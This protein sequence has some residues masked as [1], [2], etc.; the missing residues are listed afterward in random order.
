MDIIIKNGKIN[1]DEMQKEHNKKNEEGLLKKDYN[2]F[3]RSIPG[4]YYDLSECHLHVWKN[5]KNIS[6]FHGPQDCKIIKLFER[7]WKE[8]EVFCSIC[9]KKFKQNTA[10]D[11][12]NNFQNIKKENKIKK[13]KIPINYTC[14]WIYFY[15]RFTDR[16]NTIELIKTKRNKIY[17]KYYQLIY[18]LLYKPII[19]HISF[20]ESKL[21][22]PWDLTPYQKF[23]L[24]NINYK[25]NCIFFNTQKITSEYVK[26]QQKLQIL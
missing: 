6:N 16:K 15:N 12:N 4:P 21:I 9:H 18:K 8:N 2:D 7:P 20:Y 1:F 25:K 3:N 23:K 14:K 26:I 24:N 22:Y 11:T 5:A 19:Y 17:N 13:Y 10:F